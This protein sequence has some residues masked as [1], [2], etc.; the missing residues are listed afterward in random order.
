MTAANGS[1]SDAGAR[2][3][4]LRRC[5]ANV[6]AAFATAG[7]AGA[8]PSAQSRGRWRRSS[9]RSRPALVAADLPA[10]RCCFIDAAA[11]N[12]VAPSAALARLVSSTRS[13]TS[14][15]RAGSSG[16]SAF[17]FW[18]SPRCRTSLPRMSQLV[19]AAI[20]VR[21]GFLFVAIGVPG[22]FV[23]IVKRMIGRARPLVGG[24]RRSVSVQSVHLDAP[25]MPACRPATPPPPSRR[26][27]RSARCGRA[28]APSCGSMRC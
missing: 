6:A 9:S 25:P 13:P 16:R 17:C 7:A 19:L 23:T 14:A 28:R 15:S 4:A 11:I 5:A 3:R 21:V 20:T 27:W 1:I 26:W 8:H 10:R 12:A 22:L 2:S 24:S 18:R